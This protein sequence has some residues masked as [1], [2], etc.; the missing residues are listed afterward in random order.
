MHGSVRQSYEHR[1]TISDY[2][3]GAISFSP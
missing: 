3:A 2:C 1:L